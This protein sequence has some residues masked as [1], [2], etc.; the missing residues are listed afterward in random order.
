M[1]KDK[2]DKARYENLS[3]R[4]QNLPIIP[5]P[6]PERQFA[7]EELTVSTRNNLQINREI[8]DVEDDNYMDFQIRNMRRQC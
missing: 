2:G 7:E 6:F 4:F 1:K 3:N 8:H 5:L